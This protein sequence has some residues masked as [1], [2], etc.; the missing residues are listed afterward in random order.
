M[1]RN[2][3]ALIVLGFFLILLSPLITV[4][5]AEATNQTNDS[6]TP[7]SIEQVTGLVASLSPFQV[8]AII[9]LA[10][11]LFLLWRVQMFS[12]LVETIAPVGMIVVLALIVLVLAGVIK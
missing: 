2:N 5:N 10:I 1:K 12:D 7:F 6:S 8:Q 4:V 3:F 11:A 9:G